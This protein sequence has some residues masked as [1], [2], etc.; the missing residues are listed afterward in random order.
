M[1]NNFFCISTSNGEQR[2]I[3]LARVTRISLAKDSNDETVLAFCFDGQDRVVVHGSNPEDRAL[4]DHISASLGTLLD[5]GQQ[6][7]R[8]A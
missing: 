6:R 4:I 7:C 5:T 8:A 2:W 1:F 3:N